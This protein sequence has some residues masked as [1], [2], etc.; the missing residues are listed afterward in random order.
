MSYS[1]HSFSLSLSSINGDIIHTYLSSTVISFTLTSFHM[2]VSCKWK[3][4]TYYAI[5]EL[6]F[7]LLKEYALL[8]YL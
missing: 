7:H 5:G 6:P 1:F 8:Y 3:Q 4:I 2:D